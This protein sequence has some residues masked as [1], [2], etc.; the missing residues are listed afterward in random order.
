MGGACQHGG[1]GMESMTRRSPGAFRALSAALVLSGFTG[2]LSALQIIPPAVGVALLI[3]ALLLAVW[4][5]AIDRRRAKKVRRSVAERMSD[6][7]RRESR[8]RFR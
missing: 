2:P 6:R 8:V 1:M 5:I 7:E 3:V 4:A